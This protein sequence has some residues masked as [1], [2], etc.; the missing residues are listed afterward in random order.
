MVSLFANIDGKRSKMGEMEFRVKPVPPPK[1]YVQFTIEAGGSKVIDKM[2]MVNAGGVLAQLKDFDF[3]GVRYSVI[4][5]RMS[6]IYKGEQQKAEAKG[7]K[8]KPSLF[9]LPLCLLI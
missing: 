9:F 8:K 2:K 7:P 1:P 6:G 4:S 5:F 3:K